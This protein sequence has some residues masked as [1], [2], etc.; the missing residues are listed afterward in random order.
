MVLVVLEV[1]V[2]EVVAS[3]DLEVVLV[4][5]ALVDQ[6][7]SENNCSNFFGAIFFYLQKNV[8]LCNPNTSCAQK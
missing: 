7:G 2:A 8:Y 3:E 1:A 5:V 4:A 6:E